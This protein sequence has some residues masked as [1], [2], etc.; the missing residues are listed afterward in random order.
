[1]HTV[2]AWCHNIAKPASWTDLAFLQVA[3]DMV[4]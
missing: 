3:A 2:E 4:G 1:M